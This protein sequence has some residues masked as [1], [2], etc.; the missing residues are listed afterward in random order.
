MARAESGEPSI[1][2][3]GRACELAAERGIR[4]WR[5]TMTH[6]HRLAEAIAVA[7]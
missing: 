5:L 4:S 1:L 7:L 2:L 3:H 6:T